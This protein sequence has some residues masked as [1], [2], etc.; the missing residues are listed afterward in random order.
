MIRII[1]FIIFINVFI[2]LIFIKITNEIKNFKKS[3]I[4]NLKHCVIVIK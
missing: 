4:I 3:F 1:I 2:L